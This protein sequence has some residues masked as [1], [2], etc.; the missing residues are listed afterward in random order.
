[1]LR[2]GILT[3]QDAK[4]KRVLGE[5]LPPS[6]QPWKDYRGSA[7]LVVM[8]PRGSA[9]KGEALLLGIIAL[10]KRP[11][12]S[13]SV[14]FRPLGKGEWTMVP[15]THVARAVYR[16]N[17]PPRWKTSS[18]TWWPSRQAAGNLS[19]PQRQPEINHTVVVSEP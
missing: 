12:K 16:C 3:G 6:A 7:R 13:V 2:V 15:A 17:C 14:R 9:A 19:G 8:S 1:M 10:D 4:L 11:A 5:P 18:T